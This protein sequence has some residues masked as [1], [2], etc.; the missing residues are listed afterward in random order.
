MVLVA[1]AVAVASCS[2][3]AHGSGRAPA[4]APAAA[5]Y[6]QL[7]ATANSSIEAA[8]D[9]IR[10]GTEDLPATESDLR[11]IAD[12]KRAFDKGLGSVQFEPAVRPAVKSLL[13][14]D[15]ELERRLDAAAQ[16]ASAADLAAMAPDILGAGQSCVTSADALR[17]LLGLPPIS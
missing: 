10:A 8:K 14:A 13:E 2:S 15:A 7:A 9:R 1:L 3:R 4:S 6:L 17:R 16:A 12:A 11:S 5:R